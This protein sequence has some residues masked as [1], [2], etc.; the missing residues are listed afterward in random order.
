M[1]LLSGTELVDFIKVRQAKQVR[2]LVQAHHLR[3]TLAIVRCD[4]NSDVNKRT[5]KI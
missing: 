2:N 1:K 3:P 5:V 4:N